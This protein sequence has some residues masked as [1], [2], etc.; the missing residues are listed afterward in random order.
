LFEIPKQTVIMGEESTV[1][2]STARER[3]RNAARAAG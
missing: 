1:A 3:L 2:A